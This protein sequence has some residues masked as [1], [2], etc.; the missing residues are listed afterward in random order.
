VSTVSGE[1]SSK[2]ENTSGESGS[3][4]DA[5]PAENS[6][7]ETVSEESPDAELNTSADSRF[8]D[9]MDSCGYVTIRANK[10]ECTFGYLPGGACRTYIVSETGS[11]S[12]SYI[13]GGTAFYNERD[14]LG[15][16]AL[17]GAAEN[18]DG[19]PSSAQRLQEAVENMESGFRRRIYDTYSRYLKQG[20][21]WKNTD[22]E[23]NPFITDASG[24]ERIQV[25][26][27][28]NGGLLVTYEEKNG[29]GETV[30]TVLWYSAPDD[31]GE[32]NEDLN[33]SVPSARYNV[34]LHELTD[35]FNPDGN[36]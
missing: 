25:G 22:A 1:E 36:F 14:H 5:G 30:L 20:D 18:E 33:S 17:F 35:S 8:R 10:K 7:P 6:N 32:R 31:D 23:G 29:S 11:V 26:Y 27:A 13:H 3:A 19:Q 12:E 9:A 21:F 34:F 16:E 24:R 28:A 2:G 15:D 4:S